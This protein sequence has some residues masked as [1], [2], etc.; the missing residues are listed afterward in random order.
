[1]L[2]AFPRLI[3]TTPIAGWL[4]GALLVLATCSAC[5]RESTGGASD[6]AGTG[7]ATNGSSGAGTDGGSG[8]TGGSAGGSGQDDAILDWPT[9]TTVACSVTAPLAKL[10]L[11]PWL[12][13]GLAVTEN[14]AF[15][16]RAQGDLPMD[17]LLVSSLDLDGALGASI[18]IAQALDSSYFGL[19]DS[20]A[21]AQRIVLAWAMTDAQGL[22][23]LYYAELDADGGVALPPQELSGVHSYLD[24]PKVALGPDTRAVLYAESDPNMVE[25]KVML[26]LLDA[27]GAELGAAKTLYEGADF[28]W[29]EGIVALPSGFAAAYT[30][31]T[32]EGTIP[33]LAFFDAQAN[34]EGDPIAL[35]NAGDYV[36]VHAS[37][38][39]RGDELVMAWVQRSGGYATSDVA[40]VVMLARF[41]VASR[42][43]VA[44]PLP[45]MA[46][47]VDQEDTAPELV[48]LG[49][50]LGVAWS[51]G[52]VIYVCGG[53][54]PDNHLRFVV[55]DGDD[56][57]PKSEVLVLDNQ[58]PMG[59]FVD[60]DLA[61][62]DGDLL[63]TATL[64]YHVTG[65]G[66][67]ARIHCQ[68]LP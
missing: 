35:P 23:H 54:M 50:D 38:L 5:G 31:R 63:V 21:T 4:G 57:S 7:G 12:P 27:D 20:S 52:S 66:A 10:G 33:Y 16:T 9:Q 46:P 65:E 45:L 1:M 41:D 6:D 40:A 13:G 68:P 26:A 59:G 30:R 17:E 24:A 39:V 64:E 34:Q 8:A 32:N 55:L 19:P 36:Y 67:F 47:V 48:A 25:R 18:P 37:L 42:E 3:R 51:E 62:V 43:L 60:S 14:G 29:S 44:G 15:L 49:D 61:L 2:R 53:C 58:Q 22:G 28:V 11:D 56:F